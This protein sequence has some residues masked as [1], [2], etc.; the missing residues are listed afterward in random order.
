MK[1]LIFLVVLLVA[2]GGAGWWYWQVNAAP[3]NNFRTA[4]VVKD[5]LVATIGATGTLEPEEVVDIGAQVQGRIETLGADPNDKGK[6]ISWGSAVEKDTVLAQIDP[7]VYQ[8]QRDAAKADKAKANA[9]WEKAK[10]DLVIKEAQLEQAT[11]DWVRAKSLYPKSLAKSE[12]DQ[13]KAAYDVA[14]GNKAYSEASIL[15]TKAQYE[16]A[17]AALKL[18]Q[19]NLEYTTI[20]SPV[21]GVIIDRRVNIGQTVVASLSAPS[22]FLL[23]K[24]LSKMEVWATVNEADVGKTKVGQ[25][26]TF[27]VDAYPG[28]VY[29]GTVKAQGT[30][31]ARLNATMNQNVVTYTVVVSADN[32]DGSLWP[33]LTANL[34]FIVADKEKALLVPNAALRWS[35]SRRQIHPDHRDAYAKAKG[36]KKK[37]SSEADTQERGFVWVVED[38][39]V[40]PIHVVTGLSDGVN[41]EILRV[42]GSNDSLEGL[43]VVIGEGRSAAQDDSGGNPFAPKIFKKPASSKD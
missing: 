42:L 5:R 23:A 20:R 33:Y 25:P 26:V 19:T 12:Y 1:R 38:N 36:G 35:P 14:G 6:V 15:S 10:K 41:T 40:R 11:N 24:D 28:V 43:D 32:K 8:A 30:F 18:A 7:S 37:S 27:T 13:F 39:Y 9:E 31:P 17:S 2:L 16:S 4:K 34:S 29:K 3:R 21:K 22:L